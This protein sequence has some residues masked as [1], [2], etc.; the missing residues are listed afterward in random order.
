VAFNQREKAQSLQK[1][2]KEFLKIVTGAL[3]LINSVPI[4][5]PEDEEEEEQEEKPGDSA[6]LMHKGKYKDE[7]LAAVFNPITID[8]A[9]ISKG[10]WQLDML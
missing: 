5:L 7:L 2:L 8:P 10:A 4:V 3:Q 9:K 6:K 1:L